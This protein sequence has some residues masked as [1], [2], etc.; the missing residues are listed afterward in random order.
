MVPMCWLDYSPKSSVASQGSTTNR[1]TVLNASYSIH[2]IWTYHHQM[3]EY[4]QWR[5]WKPEQDHSWTQDVQGHCNY[6]QEWTADLQIPM[7]AEYKSSILYLDKMIG[8]CLEHRNWNVTVTEISSGILQK[9]WEETK[10]KRYDVKEWRTHW[11]N[12]CI[13]EPYILCFEIG[14]LSRKNKW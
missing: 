10:I 1:E 13:V 4:N 12:V 14:V 11:W 6:Y 2:I 3:L 8:T 5:E 9:N 7:K